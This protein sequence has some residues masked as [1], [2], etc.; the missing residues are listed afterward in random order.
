MAPVEP[1]N[2]MYETTPSRS[3]DVTAATGRPETTRAPRPPGSSPVSANVWLGAAALPLEVPPWVALLKAL[4][5]F[6]EKVGDFRDRLDHC[7][8]CMS[9]MG[10][11]RD[12]HHHRLHPFQVARS[13]PTHRLVDVKQYPVPALE[14]EAW[15]TAS[16][17]RSHSPAGLTAEFCHTLAAR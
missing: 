4:V 8:R 1:A 10:Q 16:R 7:L 5:D 9:L 12:K 17:R 14:P 13:L 2:E 15:T 11:V 3:S 6:L